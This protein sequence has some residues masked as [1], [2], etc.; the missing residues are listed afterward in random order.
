MPTLKCKHCGTTIGYGETYCNNC[1]DF[2]AATEKFGYS[3]L[4]K[5]KYSAGGCL[6]CDLIMTNK[7][8]KCDDCIRSHTPAP[9]FIDNY[10]KG[11]YS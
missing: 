2:L 9:P 4:W 8:S 10:T 6:G 5:Y 1:I 11:G 3:E 7:D